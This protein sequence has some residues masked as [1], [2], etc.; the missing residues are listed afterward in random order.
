MA[1]KRVLLV[2]MGNICRSAA[3]EAVMKRFAE[4]FGLDVE[5]DSAGTHDHHVGEKADGRMRAA[6]EARGYELTSRAR[7]VTRE[8]LQPGKF[9]LV[10]AMDNQNYDRLT[11]LAGKPASH[12]RIF[13]DY[14]DDNWPNDVPDPYYGDDAGFDEV[15]DMLEEGCPI[16]LQ[17]LAGEEIFDMGFED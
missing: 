4:E 1:T 3:G 5:I 10:L 8:D 14:L 15:L 6:A 7:Q 2:C 17:T 13:S 9:D 11:E 16:I 12:I